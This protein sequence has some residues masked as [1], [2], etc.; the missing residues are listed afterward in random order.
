MDF[1][2]LAKKRFSCKKFDAAKK[3]AD[4]DLEKILEAG[5]LAPTAKNNQPQRIYVLRSD[6]ALAAA[7]MLTPCRYDAPVVLVVAVNQDEVFAYPGGKYTSGAED[8]AIVATH[9]T[10]EAANLGV[11]SC[12]L[13]FFDPDKAKDV[14][15]LP[16]NEQVVL[17]MDIGY[18]APTAKPLPTHERRKPLAETVEYR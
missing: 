12:W 7:D 14:L 18:A 8:A 4:G 3:V 10:L 9:M 13:N 16:D 1:L 17:L 5:R 15:H 6:E 11:D 2:E